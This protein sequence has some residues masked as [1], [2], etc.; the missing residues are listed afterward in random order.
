M[1][2]YQLTNHG[3]NIDKLTFQIHPNGFQ[4]E[5]GYV[6]NMRYP[7]ECGNPCGS[8][9]VYSSF[10]GSQIGTFETNCFR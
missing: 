7:G 10:N 9:P 4:H 2:N 6:D 5:V 3:S 1:K 8:Q